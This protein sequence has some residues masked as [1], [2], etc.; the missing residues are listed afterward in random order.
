[1]LHYITHHIPCIALHVWL[2]LRLHLHLH[3]PLLCS[4]LNCCSQWC[5]HFFMFNNMILHLTR[6]NILVLL[7]PFMNHALIRRRDE[8]ICVCELLLWLLYMYITCLWFI[9]SFYLS[10]IHL[11]FSYSLRKREKVRVGEKERER[12]GEKGREKEIHY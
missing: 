12:E 10:F 6:F 2:R 3:S 9:H 8:F 4:K 1:M 11:S 5:L 7:P